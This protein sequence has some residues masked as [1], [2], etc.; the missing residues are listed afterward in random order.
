M[1]NITKNTTHYNGKA[2]S[3]SLR[4]F[5]EENFLVSFEEEGLDD[6]TNLFETGIIDSFGLVELITFIE[7]NF[8]KKFSSEELIS[9]S[10]SSITGMISLIE[11]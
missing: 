9:P 11:K 1:E 7:R 3:A 4:S 10:L 2:I 5:I 8:S 6:E